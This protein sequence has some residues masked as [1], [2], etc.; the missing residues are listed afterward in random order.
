M[1]QEQRVREKQGVRQEQRVRYEREGETGIVKQK[2][3][4]RQ[5]Q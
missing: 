3:R 1:R 4:V 2:K 5:K